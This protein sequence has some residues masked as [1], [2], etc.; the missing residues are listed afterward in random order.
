MYLES[1]LFCLFFRAEQV[2]FN[3]NKVKLK[4]ELYYFNQKKEQDFNLVSLGLSLDVHIYT[5]R[6]SK[7]KSR[8]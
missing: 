1:D 2:S 5:I 3:K 8:D 7:P 6:Y 4:S